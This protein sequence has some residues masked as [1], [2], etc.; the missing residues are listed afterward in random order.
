MCI[1]G[2]YGTV[3]GDEWDY[4]DASVVCSK[5]G[6]S[7]YGGSDFLHNRLHSQYCVCNLDFLF[8]I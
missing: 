4:E 7:R 3:C 2:G 5:L 1:D 6:F 8:V